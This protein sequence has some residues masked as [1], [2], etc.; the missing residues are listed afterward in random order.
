MELYSKK[1]N[2]IFYNIPKNGMMTIVQHLKMEYVTLKDIDEYKI[3]CVLRNP[4]TRIVSNF[5]F[6][7]NQLYPSNIQSIRDMNP[8]I[9]QKAFVDNDITIGFR[10]YL[11]DILKNGP[12]EHHDLPQV[13]Y[14]SND[15]PLRCKIIN[16]ISSEV[17]R[18]IDDIHYFL[19]F[20]NLEND[21]KTIIGT[22]EL[23]SDPTLNDVKNL[24]MPIAEEYRE[25]IFTLYLEDYQLYSLKIKQLFPLLP[26]QETLPVQETLIEQS[27]T[28]TH[29]VQEKT[30][31]HQKNPKNNH[32]RP[33]RKRI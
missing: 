8:E 4:L 6:M 11:E 30:I 20:D 10:C 31:L 23:S 7:R 32:R 33:G 22:F 25:Q 18:N 17:T 27:P 9:I 21:I 5:A 26:I 12:Y 14:I 29:P 1:H 24:L 3:F 15:H 13:A 19:D 16:W 2:L 28:K